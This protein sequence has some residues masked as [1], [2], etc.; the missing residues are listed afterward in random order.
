M[1]I[2]GIPTMAG[3]K[4]SE[5]DAY[6]NEDGGDGWCVRDAFCK[7]FNWKPGSKEWSRFIEDYLKV[8]S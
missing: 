4:W 7:L 2:N 3:F 8:L 1:A 6:V 5:T